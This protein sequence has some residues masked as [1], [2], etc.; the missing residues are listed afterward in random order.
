MFIPTSP[1]DRPSLKVTW[2]VFTE[3]VLFFDNSS[4]KHGILTHF[5]NI[6]HSSLGW[7]LLREQKGASVC[8]PSHSRA[9]ESQQKLARYAHHV[10]APALIQTRKSLQ[11]SRSC[12]YS[13]IF[14]SHLRRVR[15]N[16]RWRRARVNTARRL[17]KSSGFPTLLCLSEFVLPVVIIKARPSSE[18]VFYIPI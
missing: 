7:I 18:G 16:L 17:I 3:C 8:L 10:A 9:E 1:F 5:R 6:H 15:A 4:G 14:P 11:A 2:F 12:A 13:F